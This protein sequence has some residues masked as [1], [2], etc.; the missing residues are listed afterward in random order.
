M[1]NDNTGFWILATGHYGATQVEVHL[2]LRSTRADKQLL[3]LDYLLDAINKEADVL[4][5]R[6]LAEGPQI[7]APGAP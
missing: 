7:V 3:E 5:K 6:L 4:R 1:A 2:R